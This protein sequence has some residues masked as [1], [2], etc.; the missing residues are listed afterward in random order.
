MVS[1]VVLSL[2]LS[3]GSTQ[4]SKPAAL[5]RQGIQLGA[6]TST[7]RGGMSSVFFVGFLGLSIYGRS[8]NVGGKKVTRRDLEGKARYFGFEA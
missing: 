7:K 6:R 8:S 5:K 2:P 1:K 4:S 3:P